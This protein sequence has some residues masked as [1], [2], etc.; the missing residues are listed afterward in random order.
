MALSDVE[1]VV[2]EELAWEVSMSDKLRAN[3]ER[4]IGQRKLSAAENKTPGKKSEVIPLRE[5]AAPAPVRPVTAKT[6]PVK[7]TS[8][9]E[10]PGCSSSFSLWQWL[11]TGLQ[12]DRLSAVI[13]FAAVL[14]FMLLLCAA[15]VYV[16]GTTLS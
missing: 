3:L 9:V 1:E 6:W 11:V 4:V 2:R 16:L 14:C 5:R 8:P 7:I 12:K 10:P 15:L 13:V